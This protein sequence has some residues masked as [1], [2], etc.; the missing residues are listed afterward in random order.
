MI[1]PNKILFWNGEEEYSEKSTLENNKILNIFFLN[2]QE[3]YSKLVGNQF[4]DRDFL[5]AIADKPHLIG[6]NS[7]QTT[8]NWMQ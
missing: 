7:R 5:D 3:Q 4:L 2:I 8:F 1:Y 6:C